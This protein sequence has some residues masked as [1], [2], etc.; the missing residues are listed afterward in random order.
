[1][2]KKFF[3][4]Y[5]ITL[6][7]VLLSQ[8]YAQDTYHDINPYFNASGKSDQSNN[9]DLDNTETLLEPSGIHAS[10]FTATASA[11]S[12]TSTD[13]NILLNEILAPTE[14]NH[15]LTP[16]PNEAVDLFSGTLKLFY[17][18][19]SA[20]VGPGLNM[21][22]NRFYNSDH[23]YMDIYNPDVNYTQN[24][25]T[26]AWNFQKEYIRVAKNCKEADNTCQPIYVN[27]KGQNLTLF[28]DKQN[29][30]EFRTINNWH[31]KTVSNGY[32]LTSPSGLTYSF[33]YGYGMTNANRYYLQRVE[34]LHGQYIAYQYNKDLL[35]R[36]TSSNPDQVLDI[37][38]DKHSAHLEVWNNKK[39]DFKKVYH[40]FYTP[41]EILFN[42]K[43]VA[44]YNY[45]QHFNHDLRWYTLRA[46]KIGDKT[47]ISIVIV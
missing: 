24:M 5:L 41:R 12:S 43:P 23:Y 40:Y 2:T 30:S 22:I 35:S 4:A 45:E 37:T 27:S 36:V 44:Q 31:G 25:I 13:N 39:K 28:K 1:M 11:G 18:D 15:K 20:P 29:L 46:V 17:T 42:G 47:T 14:T 26:E 16:N 8:V 10:K 6:L 33:T 32:V 19:F 21:E 3:C 34:N 7:S 9:S 38:Y